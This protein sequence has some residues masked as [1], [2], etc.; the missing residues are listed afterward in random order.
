MEQPANAMRTRA[1]LVA[2]LR[3]LVGEK[4]LTVDEEDLRAFEATK[5]NR[6]NVHGRSV[7]QVMMLLVTAGVS[8]G[9][10]QLIAE[11]LYE[12]INGEGSTGTRGMVFS[13]RFDVLIG[14]AGLTDFEAMK[15]AL[16]EATTCAI[17]AQLG[18][19]NVEGS[20]SDAQLGAELVKSSKAKGMYRDLE[21]GAGDAVLS[22]AELQNVQNVIAKT[23]N[24]QE[25]M[26]VE[27]LTPK[28]CELLQG[29]ELV[30]VNSERVQW[31]ST[32]GED[33]YFRKP[34]GWVGCG[35]FYQHD[36][37]RPD[38]GVFLYGKP[39]QWALRDA[40]T[41]VFQAKLRNVNEVLGQIKQDMVFLCGEEVGD[42]PRTAVAALLSEFFVIEFVA[43]RVQSVTRAEWT[44]AGSCKLL[45]NALCVN[46][47]WVQSL[48][49]VSQKLD[50]TLVTNGRAFC[51]IGAYGRVV[52]ALR[53]GKECALKVVG[54]TDAAVAQR[55]FR[56]FQKAKAAWASGVVVEVY[57]CC[58]EVLQNKYWFVSGYSME[59]G[60]P[61]CLDHPLEL[62]KALAQL[63]CAGWI[64]TPIYKT[65]LP[66]AIQS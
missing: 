35:S 1:D 22:A 15:A 14:F 36:G 39:A 58:T 6:D 45:Q 29:S 13:P 3:K 34:D 27:L 57:A 44:A 33:K 19:P 64:H 9:P 20:K 18:R 41:C 60:R 31:L 30:F 4:K 46:N 32:L 61:P 37:K 2:H 40:V 43:D 11:A 51:G 38:N 54:S 8:V 65:Y 52:T 48:R 24:Y 66:D 47:V 21:S 26:L 28:I 53:N 50:A 25:E 16:V 56:E 42:W 12:A 7:E 49:A 59:L 17:I 23:P 63:H 5:M 55:V 10:A 62:L